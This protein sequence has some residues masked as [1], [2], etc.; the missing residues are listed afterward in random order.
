MD[1]P[2]EMGTS[3]LPLLPCSKLNIETEPGIHY[4]N[5]DSHGSENQKS[6]NKIFSMG[7]KSTS[8]LFFL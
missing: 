2:V 3:L 5:E 7:K 8:I 4:G 1:N 6:R